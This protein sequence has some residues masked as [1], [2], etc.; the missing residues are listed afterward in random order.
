MDFRVPRSSPPRAFR[1]MVWTNLRS[2]QEISKKYI[3]LFHVVIKGF[4]SVIISLC[5]ITGRFS[6]AVL[7]FL[8][9][10]SSEPDFG[11]VW[12]FQTQFLI[13]TIFLC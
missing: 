9:I 2:E 4:V 11:R 10:C 13:S 6:A 8:G 12:E 1:S 5:I 3:L 7:C